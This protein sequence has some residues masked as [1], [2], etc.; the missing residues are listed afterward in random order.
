MSAVL[1]LSCLQLVCSSSSN[2][3]CTPVTDLDLESGCA[4][5][6][7]QRRLKKKTRSVTRPCI[8]LARSRRKGRRAFLKIF[9]KQFVV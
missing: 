4:I 9:W 2:W 7:H 3:T 8:F 5:V 6:S 1:L